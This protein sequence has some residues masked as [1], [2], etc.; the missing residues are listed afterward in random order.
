MG[1]ATHPQKKNDSTPFVAKQ[2]FKC[3]GI[4]N[5]GVCIGKYIEIVFVCVNIYEPVT[6]NKQYTC[7]NRFIQGHN[8]IYKLEAPTCRIRVLLYIMIYMVCQ[9]MFVCLIGV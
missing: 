3:A 8:A 9:R 5:N 6:S 1:T 7:L 2:P 4:T